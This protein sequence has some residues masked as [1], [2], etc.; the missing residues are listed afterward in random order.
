MKRLL[1]CLLMAAGT[2]GMA[3][4]DSGPKY[5]DYLAK[6]YSGEEAPLRLDSPQAQQYGPKLRKA[7]EQPINFGG[8]Y[9]FA[10]WGAGTHCDTG[11]LIDVATGKVYF[12]PFAACNWSGYDRPFEF[13]KNSRLLV[14]AGQIGEAGTIG[15]HFFEF[16]G[17][18]FKLV[19]EKITS[20]PSVEPGAGPIE[21]ATTI[22]EEKLRQNPVIAPLLSCYDLALTGRVN[23]MMSDAPDERTYAARMLFAGGVTGLAIE[24]KKECDHWYLSQSSIQADRPKIVDAFGT[25]F[26]GYVY[27]EDRKFYASCIARKNDVGW[28][29]LSKDCE[30]NMEFLKLP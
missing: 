18:E 7:V 15:V 16:T 6:A 29:R 26:V 28:E 13:H 27:D 8:R 30:E 2:C 22:T 21:A 19:G 17:K 20:L 4:A 9:V 3:H 11:A 23:K 10:Q 25:L 14:V 5:K 24:V 1:V 12:L